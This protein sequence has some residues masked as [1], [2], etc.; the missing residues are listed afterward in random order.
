MS[1]TCTNEVCVGLSEN[2]NCNRHSDCDA[3]M[4]CSTSL[5]WPFDSTCKSLKG[6]LENC[7]EDYECLNNHYCWYVTSDDRKNMLKKCMQ[8]YTATTGSTFGWYSV[9]TSFPTY[10]E[11]KQ[12]G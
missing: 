7:A 5:N 8:I 6:T 4:Y 11:F 1:T 10:S 9:N 2:F 3:G 12:N